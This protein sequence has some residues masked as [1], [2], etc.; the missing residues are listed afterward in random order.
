MEDNSSRDKFSCSHNVI[1][2]VKANRPVEIMMVLRFPLMKK[3]NACRFLDLFN[4]EYRSYFYIQHMTYRI[5]G[6]IFRISNKRLYFLTVLRITHF[7][8][9]MFFVP[10]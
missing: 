10:N 4:R 1:S 8:K 6:F 9:G 2:L 3:Q 5:I 7:G